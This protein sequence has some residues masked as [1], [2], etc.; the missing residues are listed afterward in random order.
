MKN[1]VLTVLIVLLCLPALA[2]DKKSNKAKKYKKVENIYPAYL[3]I[4][5]LDEDQKK[6]LYELLTMRQDDLSACKK[7][8][9]VKGE[10]P[11]EALEL[12][13]KS[14]LVKIEELIGKDNMDKMKE[15]KSSQLRLGMKSMEAM[16]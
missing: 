1:L 3:E 7:E 12:I 15:Y 6:D 11:N 8:Y 16:Q 4:C 14:Y 2:Q 9:K 5:E 13:R 10:K